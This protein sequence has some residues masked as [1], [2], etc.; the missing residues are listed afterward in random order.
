MNAPFYQSLRTE[1]QMGYFVFCGAMDVMQLPGLVFIVQS[2]NQ[3]PDAIEAA[4]IEFLHDYGASID[5]MTD[6]EFEQHR[7]SLVGDVM[8]QEEKLWDRSSRYWLEIDRKNYGFDSRE[9]L[10]AAINEVSL[11]DFRKFFQTSV[12]DLARPYLVVRSFSAVKGVEAALPRNE[13]VDPLTFRSS[14]GRFLPVNE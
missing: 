13:I 12:L 7:N 10:S 3:A 4:M 14:L 5:S 11:D 6:A 8:R 2:P 9:R 1:Q